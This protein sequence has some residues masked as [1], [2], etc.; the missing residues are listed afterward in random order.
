[1][2]Q[3]PR[4]RQGG[5]VVHT[6]G[7]GGRESEG[8]HVRCDPASRTRAVRVVC[9]EERCSGP[10]VGEAR[11]GAPSSPAWRVWGYTGRQWGDGPLKG[12]GCGI[13]GWEVT[14]AGVRRGI[15]WSVVLEECAFLFSHGELSKNEPVSLLE[16]CTCVWTHKNNCVHTHICVHVCTCAHTCTHVPI[17]LPPAPLPRTR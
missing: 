11:W 9:Y 3:G 2:G 1:M 13:I 16:Q 7:R 4:H 8:L 15:M 17:K 5:P 10:A 6:G 14:S 12:G